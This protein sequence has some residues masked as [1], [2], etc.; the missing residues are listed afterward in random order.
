MLKLHDIK[1]LPE[2]KVLPDIKNLPELKEVKFMPDIKV[3]DLKVLP[4][5]KEV[6]FLPGLTETFTY[7]KVSFLKLINFKLQSP[8]IHFLV[9]TKKPFSLE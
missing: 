4:E 5:L 2:I 7:F 6:K 3:P 9:F 8:N 1:V